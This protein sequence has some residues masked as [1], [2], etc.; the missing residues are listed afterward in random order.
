LF[1]R[2]SEFSFD[3]FLRHLLLGPQCPHTPFSPPSSWFQPPSLTESMC[4]ERLATSLL[5][6]HLFRTQTLPHSELGV[7]SQRFARFRF[8][9]PPPPWTF[10][11]WT[12]LSSPVS[13]FVTGDF[14]IEVGLAPLSPRGKWSQ[15]GLPIALTRSCL[16]RFFHGFSS[17]PPPPPPV[18]PVQDVCSRSYRYLALV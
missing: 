9:F 10:L 17:P 16:F 15:Y 2:C 8:W 18:F 4:N 13:F 6:P 3:P 1:F 7:S 12:S 14:L 11:V 5:L